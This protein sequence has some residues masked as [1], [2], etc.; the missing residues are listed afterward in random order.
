MC[1]EPSQSIFDFHSQMQ[2]LWDQL[3]LLEPNWESPQ[4][5]NK[6]KTCKN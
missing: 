6:F 1:Q 3:S 5:A 4:D 2:I